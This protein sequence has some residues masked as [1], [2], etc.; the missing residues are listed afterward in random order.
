YLP[1]DTM[2]LTLGGTT[3]WPDARRLIELGQVRAQ[4]TKR[5]AEHILEATADALSDTLPKVAQYFRVSAY[6]QIGKAMAEPWENGIGKSLARPGQGRRNEEKANSSQRRP[7]AAS[8]AAIL[9]L[10]RSKQGR[11][12]GPQRLLADELRIPLS[13]LNAAI[14]RLETRKLVR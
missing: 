10:L 11:F 6:P 4:L 3:K 9:E 1:K 14:K 12:S 2:A 13:T 5:D 7:P 8:E